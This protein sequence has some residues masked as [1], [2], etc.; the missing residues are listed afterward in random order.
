V[1]IRAGLTLPTLIQDMSHG[2][3]CRLRAMAC[4]R[5]ADPLSVTLDLLRVLTFAAGCPGAL[6]GPIIHAIHERAVKLPPIRHVH[7]SVPSGKGYFPVSGRSIYAVN[8][9]ELAK[10]VHETPAWHP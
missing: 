7:W 10:G 6:V 4:G 2:G 1:F 5:S 3:A 9:H 8:A